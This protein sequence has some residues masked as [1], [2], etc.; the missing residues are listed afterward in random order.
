[1]SN[2]PSSAWMVRE[3]SPSHMLWR[4]LVFPHMRPLKDAAG[5]GVAQHGP[6]G[7]P[8]LVQPVLVVDVKHE[9]ICSHAGGAVVFDWTTQVCTATGWRYQVWSGTDATAAR[10]T[11]SIG[12]L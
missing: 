8:R 5:E 6:K 4:N 3:F 7:H 2:G 10:R 1:M 11:A 9:P 12:P